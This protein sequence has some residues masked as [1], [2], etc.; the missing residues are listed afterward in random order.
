MKYSIIGIVEIDDISYK[1][2]LLDLKREIE[3]IM[4]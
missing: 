4:E 2:I 3:I 1:S